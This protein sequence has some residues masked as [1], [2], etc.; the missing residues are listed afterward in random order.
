MIS[1]SC[2]VWASVIGCIPISN[3]DLLNQILKV[4]CTKWWEKSIFL[5]WVNS[6]LVV[7]NCLL[8]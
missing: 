6:S 4:S 2:N 7:Y 3:H 1:L 8:V 5:S